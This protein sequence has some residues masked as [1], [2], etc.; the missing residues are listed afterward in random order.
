[1]HRF[2][3][4]ARSLSSIIIIDVLLVVVERCRLGLPSVI[5]HEHCSEDQAAIEEPSALAPK[6]SKD[7]AAIVGPLA[8]ELPEGE[9]IASGVE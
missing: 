9:H 4:L 2:S 6:A 5:A 3:N 8:L 7:P 1:M